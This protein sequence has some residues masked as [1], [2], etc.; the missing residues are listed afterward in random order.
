MWKFVYFS[1]QKRKKSSKPV[2]HFFHGLHGRFSR[3][4]GSKLPTGIKL[5]TS[6]NLFKGVLMLRRAASHAMKNDEITTKLFTGC[7]W[8]FSC[9]FA[10]EVLKLFS[11]VAF[12]ESFSSL[13]ARLILTSDRCQGLVVKMTSHRRKLYLNS[14]N[15]WATYLNKYYK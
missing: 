5:R 2:L 1:K 13:P 7:L 11:F 3:N 15:T 12:R 4:I 6:F 10:I 9:F 8:T 14:V